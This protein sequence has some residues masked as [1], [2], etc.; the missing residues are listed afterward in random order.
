MKH[1]HRA[2]THHFMALPYPVSLRERIYAIVLGPLI[3]VAI[4]GLAFYFYP[5]LEPT[6]PSVPLGDIFVA[7]LYTMF[8]LTVAY[9]CA[10]VA[11]VPLAILV[12]HKAAFE[13]VLLPVFDILQSVP[14]LALFPVIIM[15][16][17]RFGNLNGAAIFILSLSM[18]WNIVFTLVGGLKLIPRDIVDAA[19]VF[20]LRG[21]SYLQRL[22]L[23]AIVPQLVTGSIL[24]VAQG[25]NITIVAE[26]L[27]TYI[28]GGTSAQDLFGVGSILVSAAANAQQGTFLGAVFAMVVIIGVFNFF[29]WQKLLHFAQRFRF[30]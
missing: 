8:R 5:I 24:A 17:V 23:P 27:H 15:L 30:D 16:F 14:T 9:C 10:V 11:A 22:V 21:W 29:V 12:T 7:A 28:P 25:W 20:G 4:M 1:L 18:V 6:G 3:I 2:H 13:K 26:V 19:R